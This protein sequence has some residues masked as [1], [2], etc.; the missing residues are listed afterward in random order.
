MYRILRNAKNY[1]W[2]NLYYLSI[3]FRRY[4]CPVKASLL[5]CPWW[6]HCPKQVYHLFSLLLSVENFNKKY[7]KT[8]R[9][10]FR[11]SHEELEYLHC[12]KAPINNSIQVT[13]YSAQA[14]IRIEFRVSRGWDICLS[15]LVVHQTIRGERDCD[16]GPGQPSLWK[17][18]IST[19]G[20]GWWIAT[21]IFKSQHTL[22]E[23]NAF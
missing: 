7:F 9:S 21:S 16:E 14:S 10:E 17:T 19:S 20:N 13:N 12:D 4:T 1:K 6:T 5:G 15:H 2:V 22:K 11:I 23:Y 18:K 8:F 3:C